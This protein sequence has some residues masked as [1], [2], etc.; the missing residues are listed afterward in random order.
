MTT[1]TPRHHRPP[2]GSSSAGAV[3]CIAFGIVVVTALSLLA[4]AVLLA[5]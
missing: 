4:I 2:Q 3:A 5:P 1:I